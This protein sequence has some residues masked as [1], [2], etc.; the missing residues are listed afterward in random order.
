MKRI[1]VCLDASPRAFTVLAAAVDNAE[2][3][4]A[5][6]SVLRVIGIPPEMDN[7]MSVDASAA[8][9]EGMKERVKL[10]LRGLL[11]GTPPAL[12]EGTHVVLGTPWDM[13]CRS[14]KDLDCDLVV[15]GSHGYSGLDRIV[16]TTAAKVVN[17]CDRS[18]LV[19]RE[20]PG[21]RS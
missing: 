4:G 13:I 19:V 17:H 6:I 16:G 12:I 21:A 20:R 5:R 18:V 8:L 14:A 2:R 10:E 7:L 3:F 9:L 11:E 15:L 1:L